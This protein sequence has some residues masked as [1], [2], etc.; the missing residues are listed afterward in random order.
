MVSIALCKSR[1][2]NP[3]QLKHLLTSAC[4]LTCLLA[5]LLAELNDPIPR[6]HMYYTSD[7]FSE[8]LSLIRPRAS[9]V[10]EML[11]ARAA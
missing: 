10:M 2:S 5:C 3:F 1:I 4:L 6:L 7:S 11:P 9:D 8:A